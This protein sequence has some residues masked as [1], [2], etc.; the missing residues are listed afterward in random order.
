MQNNVVNENLQ[1]HL[2]E[3]HTVSFF[4][5]VCLNIILF[6]TLVIGALFCN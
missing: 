4:C 5:L 1:E 2:H 6:D 3:D